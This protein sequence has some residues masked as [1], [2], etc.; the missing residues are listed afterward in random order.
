MPHS[1]QM[2][3]CAAYAGCCRSTDSNIGRK[4]IRKLKMRMGKMSNLQGYFVVPELLIAMTSVRADTPGSPVNPAESAL[5]PPG[6]L[7]WALGAGLLI[8]AGYLCRLLWRRQLR[9]ALAREAERVAGQQRQ[10][11][12]ELDES[13]ARLRTLL[14]TIP[15][16]VWLK[17]PDGVFLACNPRFERLCGATES[18]IV[19]KTDYDFI[20]AELADFFREKDRQALATGGPSANE[21]WVTYADDGHRELLETIKTPVYGPQGNLI[22]VLAIAR[23]ITDRKRD[24]D[25]LRQFKTRLTEVQRLSNSGNWELDL[26]SNKL[27]WSDEVYRIF[28]VDPVTFEPSYASFEAAIH[29]DDRALVGDAYRRS[30]RRRKPYHIVH[31]LLM[32]DGRIK[33]VQEH[34]QTVYDD[35]GRP[36]RS[37]GM[38]QDVTVR[39][40]TQQAL[41]LSEQRLQ[42]IMDN[43]PAIIYLKDLEG[44][45]LMINR[46]Y[47]NLL[48]MD[49]QNVLGKLDADLFPPE[50]AGQMRANDLRVQRDSQSLQVEEQVLQDDGLHTYISIKFPV[51]DANG[52]IYGVCG[53]STDI[54]EKKRAEQRL[55]QSAAVFENISEGMFITDVAG[56]ILDVN[57]AFSEITGYSRTEVLGANPRLWKSARHDEDFYR[58]MWRSIT[59]RGQWRGE[60]W[61]RRKDG[62][63]YPAQLTIS[64]INDG[65]GRLMHYVALFSDITSLKRSEEQL[66]R[67]AHHDPLTELP[68]RLLFNARLRHALEQSRRNRQQLALLFID[69]D[70]FKHIN[71]SFGHVVGDELLRQ[72]AERLTDC[73]RGEDTVARIGGDEFIVL[74]ENIGEPSHGVVAAKKILGSFAAP[75]PLQGRELFISPSI[76]ISVYPRD[77]S[78]CGALLRNADTAMYRAKESGRN[79]FAFYT[80]EM[81]AQALQRVSLESDLRKALERGELLLHYQPQL[82]M[83]AGE[84]IGAEALLR[85]QQ[86][87]A[88]WIPPDSFI[89]L[90]EE[91]GMILPI[92]EWV[93]YTACR[94]AKSWLEQGLAFGRISVNIA[95]PQIQRGDLVALVERVLRETG[96]PPHCLELEVTE[97]VIMEDFDRVIA[98]LESLQAMGVRLAMDDFGTGYSSLAN[99]KRL[100]IERLKIDQSFVR[101]IP[102][103]ANDMAITRAVI[104]LGLSLQLEVI[105]EG[106]ETEQQ[107]QFLL[108]EG[109]RLGQGYLFQRPVAADLFGEWVDSLR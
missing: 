41:N 51:R 105:A 38:V 54:T 103:D 85:W 108:D 73:M 79:G 30:V 19:G 35:T 80:E 44:R 31:R 57:R 20:D 96:L 43:A 83:R 56:K 61:N 60:V 77:G 48:D 9:Q 68:N 97:S 32:P 5:L 78:D 62:N 58:A 70:R 98:V 64:S 99:L 16:P 29:P 7:Y 37:Q 25:A 49:R 88:G 36:L 10:A 53:I 22:G 1:V 72:V 55:R 8:L 94:Q 74:L 18:E 92:G 46:L 66:E 67:L 27:W 69:L 45:Y 93:L 39:T 50:Q 106:V 59:T 15:D 91:N 76:G 47:E 12:V 40:E 63:L 26:I 28:E 33:H 104:A 75:F 100:P 21:E 81:T 11:R 84:L 4:P 6:W 87:E 2:V 17:D 65:E 82:D 34:C 90:A 107:R 13:H 102:H 3:P 89:P 95:T 23:D 52:E 24:A 109:C 42:A 71:D 14:D 101:D 86:P